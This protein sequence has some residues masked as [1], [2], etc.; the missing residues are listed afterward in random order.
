[1]DDLEQLVWDSTTAVGV[2]GRGEDFVLVPLPGGASERRP[3][4]QDRQAR[5]E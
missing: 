2:L 5:G 4:F 3:L 1:M